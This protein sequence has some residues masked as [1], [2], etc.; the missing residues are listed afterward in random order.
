MKTTNR[1]IMNATVC[2]WVAMPAFCA[3]AGDADQPPA[4]SPREQMR[5][6]CKADPEKCKEQM[7]QMREKAEAW[8]KKVDTNGDGKISREEA[9]ANAPRLA[10]H[11]DQIDADHDG[12]ITKEELRAAR[13]KMREHRHEGGG[14]PPKPQQ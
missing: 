3:A 14:A 12:T 9:Q 2:F 10:E 1:W 6:R 5:E 8:W 11:F 7:Q 4:G 13:E